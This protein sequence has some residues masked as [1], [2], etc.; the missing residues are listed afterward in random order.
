MKISSSEKKEEE[1][2]AIIYA[3]GKCSYT[4]YE[5]YIIDHDCLDHRYI[6]IG[7][8]DMDIKKTSMKTQ[9]LQLIVSGSSF[10]TT[11][12]PLGLQEGREGTRREHR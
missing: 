9:Q 8:L 1:T 10:A 11:T 7:Y 3:F 6:M 4:T 5:D 2:R 12:L